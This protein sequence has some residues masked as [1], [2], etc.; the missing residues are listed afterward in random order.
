MIRCVTLLAAFAVL[1]AFAQAPR[2]FTAKTLRGEIVI[3]Q[4]P[5]VRLNGESARLAPGARIRD[6]N[7]LIQLSG[8][9]M[10]QRFV[11]NYTRDLSGNLLDVWVLT[12]QERARQPWP[13]NAA[14]AAAWRFNAATQAWSKP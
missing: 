4:P 11:V 1:P 2:N 13:S 7:N 10:N 14:D 3:V 5:E 8:S 6:Q 9:L 12:P